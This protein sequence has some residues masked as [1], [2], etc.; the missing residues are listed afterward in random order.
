LELP[1][2]LTTTASGNASWHH[3]QSSDTTSTLPFVCDFRNEIPH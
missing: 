2:G 3:F 1:I